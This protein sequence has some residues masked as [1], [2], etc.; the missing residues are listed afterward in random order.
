MQQQEK[1]KS[2]GRGVGPN[3]PTGATTFLLGAASG[4]THNVC[5]LGMR[6]GGAFFAVEEGKS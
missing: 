5:I 2:F 1:N 4:H 3:G 6:L